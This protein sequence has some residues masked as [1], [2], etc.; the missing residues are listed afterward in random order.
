MILENAK[1]ATLAGFISCISS[2]TLA[3]E[4]TFDIIYMNH[5]NVV[6]A[7][8]TITKET[9]DRFQAFLDTTQF[10]GY[11]FLIHLNS[12]GGNLYGGMEL[13]RMIRDQGLTTDIRWYVPRP[14]GQDWYSPE[15]GEQGA[16]QC[17]SACALAFLGGKV[18]EISDGAIIGFHQFSGGVDDI[19]KIQIGT[20]LAAGEV[21]KYLTSMGASPSLFSRM[22]EALP[23]DMYVPSADDLLVYSIISRDAF[24]GFTL[25]PYGNG[26]L[27]FST[28]PENTKGTNLVYQVTT[29]CKKGRPF[30]LLSG[31]PDEMG[32]SE[33]F[34]DRVEAHLEGFGVSIDGVD[35][36]SYLYPPSLVKFRSGQQL[37]EIEVDKRFL[38]MI[39]VGKTQGT[40]LFPYI[41]G[42]R[43]AF[44]IQATPEDIKRISSSFKLCTE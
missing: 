30:I 28:F 37:A 17:Y 18:R 27:A 40:V 35:G 33:D 7:D 22:S 1:V 2:G 13:G 16:G 15:Y 25:E 38:E 20:Q 21:L 14:E 41:F 34:A 5:T 23:D 12:P 42:G 29:Y 32:L 31:R 44:E 9:P 10:D 8:G 43:M 6:V 36:S 4:M 24:T 3:K 26:V 11:N 19:E 39:E